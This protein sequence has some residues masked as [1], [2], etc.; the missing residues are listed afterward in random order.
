M[1]ILNLFFKCTICFLMGHTFEN[2]ICLG[3]EKL[4]TPFMEGGK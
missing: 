2:G 3:C 1:N 4:D